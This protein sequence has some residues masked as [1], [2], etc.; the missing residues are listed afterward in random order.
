M[1]WPAVDQAKLLFIFFLYFYF[2]S[3]FDF[4]F[5]F[6]MYLVYEFIINN[7]NASPGPQFSK[8]P[9][10]NLG[11]RFSEE[12]LRKKKTWEHFRNSQKF[13]GQT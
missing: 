11:L 1:Y 13:L 8:L 4:H 10:L 9:N 7:I 5:F 2:F 3:S 6:I 12:N